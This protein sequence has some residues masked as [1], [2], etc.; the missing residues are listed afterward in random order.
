MHLVTTTPKPTVNLTELARVEQLM[1]AAVVAAA[2]L[3]QL[4][5]RRWQINFDHPSYAEETAYVVE[6]EARRRARPMMVPTR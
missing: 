2:P 5:A 4:E 3:E 6:R 1:P